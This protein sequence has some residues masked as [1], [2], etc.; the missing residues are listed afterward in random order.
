M[1]IFQKILCL[2]SLV[3]A[4]SCNGIDS[5]P[6]EKT[7]PDLILMESAEHLSA[8]AAEADRQ[9]AEGVIASLQE[10]TERICNDLQTPCQFP[11]VIEIYPDQE[12]FDS[13][14]MNP[15]MR[16]FFAVSGNGKIQMVSPANPAPHEISYDDGVLVAVHE[17]VHLALDE[18]NV[19]MPTWLDEGAAVYIGPHAP[20]AMVCETAF[21]FEMIPSFQHLKNEYDHVQAP[22][23]FAYTAVDFI[24]RE[25]GTEKLNLVL[26]SPD[27]MN[28]ILGISDTDFDHDWQE[29]IRAQYH[30]DAR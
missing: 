1:K 18:I 17:F 12:T 24:V 15:E 6:V 5:T 14:V 4:V 21:P 9:T 8:W 25:H 20:Y 27:E 29:F 3:I 16:G 23:L 10:N 11:V 28:V 13:H 19:N 22:D 2:C 7:R 30:N 26:R